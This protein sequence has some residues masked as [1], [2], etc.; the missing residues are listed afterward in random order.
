M[1]LSPP[2]DPEWRTWATASPLTW[3]RWPIVAYHTS[4]VGVALIYARNACPLCLPQSLNLLDWSTSLSAP[5][6]IPCTNFT[7]PNIAGERPP[8]HR[9]SIWLAMPGTV[10]ALS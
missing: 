8:R 4:R 6:L 5:Q 1:A 9:E 3:A 7:D 10:H 2:Y